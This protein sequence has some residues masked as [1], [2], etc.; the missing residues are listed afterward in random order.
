MAIGKMACIHWQRIQ[1]SLRR[2]KA[3]PQP[4]MVD[5]F[6]QPP[7]LVDVES[8]DLLAVLVPV[9]LFRHVDSR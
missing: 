9:L 2:I 1:L 8:L 6:T 4:H 7:P 5:H 3:S